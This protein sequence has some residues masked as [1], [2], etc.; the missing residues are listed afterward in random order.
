MTNIAIICKSETDL[1]KISV[2]L[3]DQSDFHIVHTGRDG[4]D[5]L[6]IAVHFKPDILIMDLMLLDIE[7]HTLAPIIK[8]KSP[9]TA[10]MVFSSDDKE[11]LAGMSIKAGISAY[12][13]KEEDM[14]RLAN[15]V[16]IV[17][18]GACYIS[19]SILTRVFRAL[20]LGDYLSY[21][22]ETG[23]IQAFSPTERTLIILLA[24]G[25]SDR[26]I[27]AELNITPGAVRNCLTRIRRKTGSKSRTQIVI[28]ALLCGLIDV[29]Q[30]R[31]GI[32]GGKNPSGLETSLNG[33]N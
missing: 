23:V 1:R 24:R 12:L 26:Q 4:Y 31:A 27:A 21:V 13:L 15:L 3:S 29:N 19:P 6:H 11:E 30:L 9:S 28:Y 22:E 2:L 17:S 8:R 7:G 10:I 16:R 32:T 14:D 5:A 25:L 20:R 33:W 18:S